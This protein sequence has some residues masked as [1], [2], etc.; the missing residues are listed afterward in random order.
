MY[1]RDQ[2]KGALRKAAEA[3]DFQAANE[4][5]ATLDELYPS[6]QFADMRPEPGMLENIGAGLGAG[7]VGLYESAALGAITPFD[8]DTENLLRDYIK[9]GADAIRPEGG[10]PEALSY[11]LPSAISSMMAAAPTALLGPLAP[12]AAGA[13]FAASGAGEASERARAADLLPSERG[14]A[15]LKGAGVGLLDIVPYQRVMGKFGKLG[16]DIAEK[17]GPKAVEGFKSRVTNA[18][19]TGGMEAAQETAS[20]YLQNLI[21]QGY[22][23]DKDIAEGLAQ[24]GGLGFGAGAIVQAIVDFLPG[25]SRG[26]SG[27]PEEGEEETGVVPPNPPSPTE[28]MEMFDGAVAPPEQ[29]EMFGQAPVTIGAVAEDGLPQ[30]DFLPDSRQ[31]DLVDMANAQGTPTEQVP[32]EAAIAKNAELDEADMREMYQQYVMAIQGTQQSDLF[33]Q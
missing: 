32:I 29:M 26:P 6:E 25:R 1:S 22:R 19:T 9:S 16:D 3:G 20:E 10:D 8:E 12:V 2:L 30:D 15:A 4:L 31:M 5:A 7:A 21:E 27:A 33:P 17:M 28:Q 13:L 11:Q 23:P 24:A 14:Q 18:L